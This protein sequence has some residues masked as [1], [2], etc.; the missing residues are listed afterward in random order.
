MLFFELPGAKATWAKGGDTNVLLFDPTHGTNRYKMKLCSFTTVG[1]NSATECLAVALLLSESTDMFVWAFRC[2]TEVFRVPP[3]CFF[4]DRDSQIETA[5]EILVHDGLW[6]S[7]QH[8]YCIFHLYKNLWEKLRPLFLG[9]ASE[10]HELNNRFWTIAKET[11]DRSVDLFEEEWER[12]LE[13]FQQHAP[14]SCSTYETT[15]QW[16]ESLADSKKKWASRYVWSAFTAG[17]NSTQRAESWQNLV[18]QRSQA[19]MLVTELYDTLVLVNAE[20]RARREVAAAL[21]GRKHQPLNPLLVS[22]KN[23]VT[24]FAFS[25]LSK[26]H[27]QSQAYTISDEFRRGGAKMYKVVRCEIGKAKAPTLAEDGSINDFGTSNHE[28]Y[29]IDNVEHSNGRLVELCL[30]RGANTI[31]FVK[32]SCQFQIAWGL[33]CRHIFKVLSVR[34]CN[35]LPEGL[36]HPKWTQMSPTVRLQLETSMLSRQLPRVVSSITTEHNLTPDQ[37]RAAMLV[38]ARL[39]FDHGCT[40]DAAMHRIC[41]ALQALWQE[42]QA[43][44][45]V[46]KQAHKSATAQ[47]GRGRGGQG[48]GTPLPRQG[49]PDNEVEEARSSLLKTIRGSYLQEDASN[50]HDEMLA[51]GGTKAD[52]RAYLTSRYVGESSR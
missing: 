20:Q 11:D 50:I 7:V 48:Q 6:A 21:L 24:P 15:R 38:P 16:L 18:K 28:D 45:V 4:T 1:E 5:V 51:Y 17:I 47:R 37:R 19:N 27:E 3:T 30:Q 8:L 40:S 32:C 9:S 41:S 14:S 36:V 49:G 43:D 33:P 44:A 31:T 22:L 52:R 46:Q 35:T 29:G 26:Q 25:L 10:W 23:S 2:F 12:I 39:L 34:D 13:Y 42:V